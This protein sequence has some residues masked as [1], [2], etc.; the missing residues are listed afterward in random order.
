[1]YISL[2]KLVSTPP[3]SSFEFNFSAAKLASL[4]SFRLVT[5]S[6]TEY[7]KIALKWNATLS[8]E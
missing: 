1:M 7:D 5:N 6:T 8:S 2:P 3:Y 4:L